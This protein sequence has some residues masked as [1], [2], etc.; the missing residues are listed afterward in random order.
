MQKKRTGTVIKTENW[1]PAKSV[2]NAA[3]RKIARATLSYLKRRKAAVNIVFVSD[4]EIKKLNKCFLN[5]D[6]PTDVISFWQETCDTFRHADKNFLGD[7]A[8]STDRARVNAGLFGKTYEEEILLYVIHGILHLSGYKDYTV[9]DR[10]IMENIQEEI[11]G[12]FKK[13]AQKT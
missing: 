4:S 13:T 6:C 12:K 3:V 11:L 7:I 1:N 5:E 8:I 10:K 2:D 9:R